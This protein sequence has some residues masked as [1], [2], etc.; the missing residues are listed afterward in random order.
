MNIYT[1]VCGLIII[2]LLI[3]FYSRQNT[4][5]MESEHRFVILLYV[6][7]GCILTDIASAY[8]CSNYSYGDEA[9]LFFITKLYLILHVLSTF[10][11]MQY[12]YSDI[13]ANSEIKKNKYLFRFSWLI[14][15]AMAGI[16]IYLS[17][18]IAT[19]DE[20]ICVTGT[21]TRADE[22]FNLLLIIAILALVFI[23]RPYI[24]AKRIRTIIIWM[25]FWLIAG[26][27]QYFF[28]DIYT[29]S[30]ASALGALVVFFEMV[31]PEATI[32][33]RTG[34][35]S[36]SSI[37][38]FLDYKY[39]R[40]DPFSV[41]MISFRTKG[42]SAS[43]SVL[44]QQSINQLSDFL[45]SIKYA[46]AFDTA[47]GYFL[48][49]FDNENLMQKAKSQLEDFFLRMEEKSD[50]DTA[51]T[52][53]HPFYIM[54]PKSNIATS[55]EELMT[56]LTGF[57]PTDHKTT[58]KS[59]VTVTH[60]TIAEERHKK[61]VED[62]VV[63]AL[64]DD[65]IEVFYQPIF[66]VAQKSFSSAE[67]LVRIRL[68]NGNYV[69]PETF[70]PIAEETG[71][72]MSLSD[73]IYKK[74]MS[75][76]KLFHIERL[77]IDKIQLNL[78]IRQAET[79]TFATHIASLLNSFDLSANML[80]LEITNTNIIHNQDLLLNNMH[81]LKAGGLDFALDDFGSGSSNLNYLL[82]MPISIIKLDRKLTHA[83]LDNERATS[84]L[85]G[86]VDISHA[87]DI[88]LV[89]EGI[90][91]EEAMEHMVELGIDYI[92]GFYYSRPLSEREFLAFIQE[93]NC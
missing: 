56:V 53:L 38:Y 19:I 50:I 72:I 13:C 76:I 63:E 79:A 34:H 49:I 10:C 27:I 17:P 64:L 37:R 18:Q 6:S 59:Q 91:S 44:L 30:F 74:T 11:A 23:Y 54:V 90:E 29:V 26:L 71:H 84:I 67:A 2:G 31:N 75:F 39:K 5:E 40:K 33:R 78:S 21:I 47:G 14:F 4:L 70:I 36:S 66:S 60:E 55:G 68:K 8:L 62:M 57:I 51:F 89:A 22:F 80:N 1:Q 42:E 46:K 58:T 45:F 85:K 7:L 43:D 12:V 48:L 52:L 86:I 24:K 93:K 32:S 41:L 92:Q 61:H 35:F 88:K 15:A 69:L 73:A 25:A 9:R 81:K 82:E 87:M 16:I 3:F 77:G 28:T 83:Y 20:K 65:R